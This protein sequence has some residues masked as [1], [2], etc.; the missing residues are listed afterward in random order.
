MVNKNTPLHP[1][2]R[3]IHGVL[4]ENHPKNTIF[5]IAIALLLCGALFCG[6]AA[7]EDETHPHGDITFQPW[8]HN[9]S[10]PNTAGSYYL[11]TDVTIRETWKVQSGT[12]NLCLNGYSITRNGNFDFIEINGTNNNLN[13]YDCKGGGSITGNSSTN[14]G[15][16]VCVKNGG[17]FNMYG[18]SI[19]GNTANVDGGGVYVD[20]GTF[21]MKNGSITGNTATWY[22]GEEKGRGGGVYIRTG[23]FTMEGGS[24]T[25]NVAKY[26]GSDYDGGG[27]V[28]VSNGG[29]FNMKGGSI[30]DNTAEYCGGVYVESGGTF[31]MSDNASIT[32]NNTRGGGVYLYDGRFD[33]SFGSISGNGGGGVY[34]NKESHFSVEGTASVM[35]NSSNNVFLS[36]WEGGEASP[37]RK[38]DRNS[39]G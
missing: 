20:G 8:D 3:P 15:R 2:K 23:T 24:I 39:A 10:L 34:V 12:T 33:L 17:T 29:M 28:R 27:G 4:R 31:N 18:G 14:N 35:N 32:G 1:Q 36:M 30:A 7:A 5:I 38:S 22:S 37:H 21:T 9:D 16:G 26:Y 13:L 19:T 6:A 11:T 25:R